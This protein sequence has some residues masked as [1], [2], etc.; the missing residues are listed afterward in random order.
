MAGPNELTQLLQEWAH[1]DEDA[2]ERLVPRV[3][4]EL[5]RL[6]GLYM[7]GERSN[8]PLQTTALI[9]EA[10]IRLIGWK[11]VEWKNRGHFFGVAAQLMRRILVDLARAKYGRNRRAGQEETHLDEECVFQP[12]KSKDLIL[13]DEALSRLAEID[14]RKSRVVELRFF[15]GLSVDETAAVMHISDRTV[16]R[17]WNLAR[18]WLH[19]EITHS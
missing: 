17:E 12:E 5:H 11:N 8:H 13:L 18:A 7:A 16:L 15:G 1:G 6:A 2:L 4:R 19:R 9:N 3:Q 14:P 10:Y